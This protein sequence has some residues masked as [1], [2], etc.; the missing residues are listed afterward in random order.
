MLKDG[1]YP[2]HLK[3]R[4]MSRFG[5]LSNSAMAEALAGLIG[6]GLEH[7]FLAHLSRENNH[8]ELALAEAFEIRD[9]YGSD[10]QIRVTSQ[11]EPTGLIT[12]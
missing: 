10:I 2:W 5:H 3:Q 9:E 1:G 7:L 11:D 4:I 12:I 6:N 8:P